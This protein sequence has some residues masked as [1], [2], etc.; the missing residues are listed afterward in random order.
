MGGGGGG[1]GGG[2]G[3][4]GNLA[5]YAPEQEPSSFLVE[6]AHLCH[7]LFPIEESSP[8]IHQSTHLS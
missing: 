5:A 2:Y 8:K 3:Q 4:R 1:G 6:L 7:V